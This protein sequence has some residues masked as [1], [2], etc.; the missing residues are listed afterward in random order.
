M[1]AVTRHMHPAARRAILQTML[2]L[3][4]DGSEF[5]RYTPIFAVLPVQQPVYRLCR[6]DEA[7]E[8]LAQ[9]M[10]LI[11]A[12]VV[13]VEVAPQTLR[14]KVYALL[15]DPSSTRAARGVSVVI[16]SGI[17]VSTAAYCYETMPGV[18]SGPAEANRLQM[19]EVGMV[20]LFTAEYIARLVCCPHLREFLMSPMNAIDLLSV[21]P[22]YV[23]LL[24]QQ[25]LGGARP[26]NPP[27]QPDRRAPGFPLLNQ[28]VAVEWSV[29][30]RPALLR[31]AGECGCAVTGG[32][33]ECLWKESGHR[34]L[35]LSTQGAVIL[36]RVATGRH[37]PSVTSF[38]GCTASHDSWAATCSC[39]QPV[40]VS[41]PATMPLRMCVRM[42][43]ETF[44]QVSL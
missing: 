35:M 32:S 43:A 5:A 15:S 17:C 8:V 7:A 23:S 13:H 11:C 25:L 9:R 2:G 20:A 38:C 39:S 36:Q 18:P 41:V 12:R 44:C 4:P 14:S 42:K 19:V 33:W 24:S 37:A 10:E 21:L 6:T 3:G 16:L 34:G 28:G 1:V 30:V 27:S 40:S 26:R 31:V 22:Y 29:C